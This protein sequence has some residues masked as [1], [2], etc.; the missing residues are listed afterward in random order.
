MTQLVL[1]SGDGFAEPRLACTYEVLTEADP[2]EHTQMFK[3]GCCQ[4]TSPPISLP[5]FKKIFFLIF[6]SFTKLSK[7][8]L[9]KKSYLLLKNLIILIIKNIKSIIS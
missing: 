3:L 9:K 5:F 8:V 7:V 6:I 2:L 4:S 1:A